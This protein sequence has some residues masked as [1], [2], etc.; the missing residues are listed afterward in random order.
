METKYQYDIVMS[1]AG[2]DRDFVEKCAEI[3]RALGLN[4]F[5][6]YYEQDTLWGKDLY[7]YLGD[8]YQN[9]SK[10]AMVFISKNYANKK[11][12]KHE[13]KFMTARDFEEDSEYILPV[14]IDDTSLEE[15]PNTIGYL[16]ATTP[17]EIAKIVAKK[18][19][20]DFDI[21]D[22]L[23]ILKSNLLDYKIE[24]DG[25]DVVFDCESESF[26]AKYPL[27]FMMEFYRCNLIE[28]IFLGASIVPW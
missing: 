2:E 13:L 5:Y 26:Y 25:S 14:K 6:D 18:I 7:R 3:L 22:M 15:L 28:S 17:L 16:V 1:F 8:I 4:V 10:Y 12:T 19:N 24:I 9:K 20:K 23:S 21:D 11:W 27:G